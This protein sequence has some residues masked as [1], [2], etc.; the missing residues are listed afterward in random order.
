LHKGIVARPYNVD[1]S[2]IGLLKELDFVFI[3]IDKRNIK[4]LIIPELLDS[5]TPLVDLGMGVELFD[6]RFIDTIR[7]ITGT[8]NKNSHL[9]KQ[10]SFEDGE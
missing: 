6:D 9:S 1:I 3:C 8:K 10:V 5:C 7:V 4:E 2:N